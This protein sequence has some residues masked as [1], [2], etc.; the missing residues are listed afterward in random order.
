MIRGAIKVGKIYHNFHYILTSSI[1][2]LMGN[3]FS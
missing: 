3:K 1:D 2:L